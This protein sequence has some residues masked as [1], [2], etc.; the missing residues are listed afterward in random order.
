MNQFIHK[1]NIR[2]ISRRFKCEFS[3][4]VILAILL[5]LII[6]EKHFYEFTSHT[7]SIP[8][9]K[10]FSKVQYYFLD[11]FLEMKILNKNN[12]TCFL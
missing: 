2:K 11:A 9:V 10:C 4:F 7:S 1:C 8:Q 6:T 12:V 5:I 3:A